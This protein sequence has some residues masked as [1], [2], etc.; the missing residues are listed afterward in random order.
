MNVQLV[1]RLRDSKGRQA[2]FNLEPVKLSS[3]V[4]LI[5]TWQRMGWVRVQLDMALDP[6]PQKEE[7]RE[8][9]LPKLY[10]MKCGKT[11]AV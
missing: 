9:E 1:V 5:A 11:V 3:I 8:E 2:D 4:D 6:R 7:Q 10:V